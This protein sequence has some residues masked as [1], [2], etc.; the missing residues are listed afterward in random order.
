MRLTVLSVA[1]P[2]TPVGPNAVGGSE[3]I[4]TLLDAA[5]T[6]AG[7]R[8]IV[9]AC[10]G[11][12][13]Q[14]ELAAT[15][16][17]DGAITEEVRSWAR[18]QHRI[19]IEQTLKKTRVD[20]VHMHSLDFWGYVPSGATPVLATLHLPPD[21]YP[22][23][24]FRLRRR[25]TYLHCVSEAQAR[26]CPK[27]A[28]LL[29]PIENGVDIDRLT[30]PLRKRDFVLALGRI[31]PEK[32]LHHA[33]EAAAGAGAPLLLGGEVFRYE[34]HERYFR[35]EIQPRL[36]SKRR[37]LGPLGFR[38]KR[39][40]LTEARCLLIPSK[41]A[42]TSSLVAMEALACGTPV[43]AFPSGALPDIVEDGKT[44]F[45]VNDE[46]EMSA[47]LR[48][49]KFL[50]PE[51]CRRTARERFSAER[52]TG[53]YIARYLQLTECAAQAAPE[54]DQALARGADAR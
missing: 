14:G 46:R 26:S 44:G 30:V 52:M 48:A 19:A 54:A 45:L 35:Q 33:L 13:V 40:L 11:S 47:A 41:V 2:L 1:Y 36:D 9:V 15:P 6:R 22:P 42:E 7:H 28:R 34:A 16:K 8:S 12:E 4:L 37:F 27:S 20:I 31:C 29:P 43:I 25:K 39:R 50:D 53:R 23:S 3:Q 10:E 17:W 51:V 18:T 38:Q 24:V 21:W 5:L 32:G 49:A